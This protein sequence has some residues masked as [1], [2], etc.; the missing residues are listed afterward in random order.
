MHLRG[1]HVQKL[2]HLIAVRVVCSAIRQHVCYT[3]MLA[4]LLGDLEAAERHYEQQLALLTSGQELAAG[5][6]DQAAD[7]TDVMKVKHAL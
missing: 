5:S 7:C 3:G 2:T 6:P 1:T 4:Q